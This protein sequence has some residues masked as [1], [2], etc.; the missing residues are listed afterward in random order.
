[1]DPAAFKSVGSIEKFSP[2]VQKFRIVRRNNKT[3]KSPCRFDDVLIISNCHTVFGHWHWVATGRGVVRHRR[4][5]ENSHGRRC[6][7]CIKHASS[8]VANLLAPVCVVKFDSA[9]QPTLNSIDSAVQ[10]AVFKIHVF[11]IRI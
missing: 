2:A 9:S 4:V 11:E 1:M 5:I 7:H 3:I 6:N 10:G 8:D